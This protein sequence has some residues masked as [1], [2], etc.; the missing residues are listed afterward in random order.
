MGQLKKQLPLIK[1][2][3]GEKLNTKVYD[4]SEIYRKKDDQAP[5]AVVYFDNL[6][7]GTNNDI[8]NKG[9]HSEGTTIGTDDAGHAPEG[10]V[11]LKS[12]SGPS[13]NLGHVETVQIAPTVLKA[14]GIK[15]Y[16]KLP[17]KP[18]I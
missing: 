8:G 11:I 6:R 14:L 13:G 2:V 12:S 18:L 4:T 9:L 16:K 15:Q 10:V 5:D 3:K 17:A 7:Y 1:G